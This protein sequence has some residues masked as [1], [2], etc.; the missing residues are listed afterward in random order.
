MVVASC[1]VARAAE[2]TLLQGGVGN[3]ISVHLCARSRLSRASVD[4]T[5]RRSCQG[6]AGE[7]GDDGGDG[8]LGELHF[9]WLIREVWLRDFVGV[10]ESSLWDCGQGCCLVLS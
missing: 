6:A 2:P 3:L 7:Q 9:A 10:I 1:L 5:L 4:S 8:K